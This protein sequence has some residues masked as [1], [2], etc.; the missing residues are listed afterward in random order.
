MK[1]S[2]VLFDLDGT[3]TEPFEGITKAVQYSLRKFGI[4]VDDL[5]ELRS[6]IGPPLF[7]SF[8]NFY[9]MS[10]EESVKAV[11]YYREYYV[12][13]GIYECSVY[14]GVEEMLKKL[15][16][17]PCKVILATSKPEPMAITV[18]SHFGLDKYF[19]L[20]CG[21]TLDESRT[22]KELVVA[23]ALENTNVQDKSSAIMIGDRKFDVEGAAACGISTI[24]VTYGHGGL[25]ELEEAGAIMTF[26]DAFS[27][28]DYLLS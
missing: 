25:K 13:T 5:N 4:E 12:P 15:S 3:I 21:A 9:G 27:L 16:E 23:Y 18:L 6:F 7:E 10:K 2:H 22:K 20:I 14:P 17:S 8:R 26:D 1:Y 19:D 28:T 24:G 11:E